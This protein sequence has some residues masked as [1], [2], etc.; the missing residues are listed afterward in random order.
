MLKPGFFI[1]ITRMILTD[2][3]LHSDLSTDGLSP[4]EEEIT[5]AIKHGLKTLCFTE[6][7]D[8]GARD[9]GSFVTDTRL[10]REKFLE[11]K[12]KY[13][14]RI[15]LLFGI[16]VGLQPTDVHYSYFN[17][18]ADKWDFDFI[19]GSSH[20]VKNKDPYY[21]VFFEDYEDDDSAYSA[22]FEEELQNASMYDCYDS[23]G[24]LDYILRYGASLNKYF[25][26]EKFSS[27]LDPLLKEIISHGKC[28][29][30]N[31]A[32]IRKGMGFANTHTDILTRYRELG[33]LPPTIGSDAHEAKDMAADFDEVEKILYDAGFS[34]YSIFRNRRREEISL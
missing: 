13:S 11:M 17:E 24:H 25:T 32:G 34:S 26:Y 5:C 28:I 3:H 22:Y 10:Y 33:G 12:E 27:I 16:E 23:Y 29:E 15:G 9:D 19:I 8:Y 21:P 1:T 18:L 6:H 20:V 31:S 14:D 30:V 2:C 7:N 4:M